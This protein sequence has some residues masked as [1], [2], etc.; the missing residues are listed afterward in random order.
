MRSLETSAGK[1]SLTLVSNERGIFNRILR[2]FQRLN[3]FVIDALGKN[4]RRLKQ[5]K[6][7]QLSNNFFF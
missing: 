4:E 7:L 3:R 5:K 6:L 1:N 2:L